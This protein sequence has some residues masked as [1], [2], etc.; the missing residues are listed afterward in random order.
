M[1]LGKV[2]PA[3]PV[4]GRRE[5]RGSPGLHLRVDGEE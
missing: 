2:G 1:T 3:S 5:G 4:P